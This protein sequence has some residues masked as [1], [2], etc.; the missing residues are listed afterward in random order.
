ME[1][2]V[3]QFDETCLTVLIRTRFNEEIECLD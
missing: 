2:G 3:Y 1:M